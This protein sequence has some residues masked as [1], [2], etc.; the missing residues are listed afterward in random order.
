MSRI[1][2][3]AKPKS[4]PL[5]RTEKLLN[6]LR[7]ALSSCEELVRIIKTFDLEQRDESNHTQD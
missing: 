2:S 4:L 1:L 3:D 7:L 5:D 6:D